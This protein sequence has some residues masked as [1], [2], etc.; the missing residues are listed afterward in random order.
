MHRY[1][2]TSSARVHISE[3]DVDFFVEPIDDFGGCIAGRADAEPS[4]GLVA[5]HEIANGW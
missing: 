1:S 5:R 3:G 4:A 2:I